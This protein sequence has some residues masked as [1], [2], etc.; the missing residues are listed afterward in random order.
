[1]TP[2]TPPGAPAGGPTAL[3]GGGGPGCLS[4][5]PAHAGCAGSAS[6]RTVL[7]TRTG[8]E[9]G[10]DTVHQQT[11]TQGHLYR[12]DVPVLATSVAAVQRDKINT[13]TV[14]SGG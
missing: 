10:R 1:M 6:V 13:P 12:R 9:G 5:V 3:V 8:V 14:T 4:S 7:P 2:S 11:P